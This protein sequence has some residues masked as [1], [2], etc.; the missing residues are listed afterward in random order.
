MTRSQTFSQEGLQSPL[1][2]HARR[3][4]INC[5]LRTFDTEYSKKVS[6]A[7]ARGGILEVQTKIPVPD[8]EAL[9]PDTFAEDYFVTRLLSKY[10][11]PANDEL[12]RRKALQKF[13]KAEVRCRAVNEL[14]RSRWSGL[15]IWPDRVERAYCI[16][17]R[18]IREILGG[19]D[20]TQY[21]KLC[22]FGPGA[23]GS[24]IRDRTSWYDK[25]RDFG[26]ITPSAW[27][28]LE[29]Y[30]A[31]D[32]RL[33]MAGS[34]KFVDSNSL[35]F[36]PKR[37]DEHRIAAKEPRW[38]MFLQ[39]GLG[40]MI[41]S[42]LDRIGLVIKNQSVRN[43]ESARTAIKR[44]LA[45]L[46]LSSASD[47]LATNLII[48]LLCPDYEDSESEHSFGD[49]LD[50]LL[51][52]RT[53]Y[54]R[55]PDGK[56]RLEKIS[57]MGNGF[58]FPLETLVFY[59][60]AY[61]CVATGSK[62]FED[63]QVFGDDIIVPQEDSNHLVELLESVGFSVNTQKSFFA[64]EFFES[65]GHDYFRG[66]NVRPVFI[67]RL[68]T[69]HDLIRLCNAIYRYAKQVVD[70]GYADAR[71][72]EL[73][74]KLISMV[75]VAFRNFVPDSFGDLGLHATA[76]EANLD[77]DTTLYAYRTRLFKL[78]PQRVKGSSYLGHLYSKLSGVHSVGDWV[79][80]RSSPVYVW[81]KKARQKWAP[82][83]FSDS[84]VWI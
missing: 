2:E 28:V 31:R 30:F 3:S 55:T 75:P 68:D 67:K 18:K 9:C 49:W 8:V 14:Y 73:H 35:F 58:T 27:H 72:R 16:A 21:V 29:T 7:L 62:R 15:T 51:K 24:T 52:V 33:S 39:L 12:A 64:G 84:D 36:V 77:W 5:I 34:S 25:Y 20:R 13:H 32:V 10:I 50:L 26:D 17:R 74:L 6:R 48:D 82:A 63:I 78:V 38:N 43:R 47:S 46:D 45:T 53:H 76:D 66:T 1:T 65:C 41:E 61:G 81:D 11:L 60:L 40:R 22:G 44:G 70:F 80:R 42:R 71:F 79:I 37:F 56:I 57:S 83:H 59:A 4:A 19:F 23:D 69:V 54:M